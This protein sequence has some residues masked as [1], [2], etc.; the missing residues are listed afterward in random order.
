M[1]GT[2]SGELDLRHGRLGDWLDW[3]LLAPLTFVTSAGPITA[4]A[5]FRTDGA[6]IPRVLWALLSPTG[7]WLAPAVIHDMGC[8][9]L[10]AGTP[11]SM[12]PTRADVDA[13]F[14]E[15]MLSVGTNK[16]TAWIMWAAVR[17]AGILG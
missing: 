15:A 8:D 12:M 9:L 4:P 3:T 17:L 7:R 10:A 16:V 5:G 1:T 14:H 6:S 2:F 13:V 11:H